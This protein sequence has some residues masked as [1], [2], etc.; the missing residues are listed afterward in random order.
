MSNVKLQVAAQ[1]YMK[2]NMKTA[3]GTSLAAGASNLTQAMQV[4]NNDTSKPLSFKLKVMYTV[5]GQA[6]VS[7]IKVVTH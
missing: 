1:K 5:D 4:I 3:S 7:Q 6:P 2:L